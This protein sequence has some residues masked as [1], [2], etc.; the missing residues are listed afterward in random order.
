MTGQGQAEVS[1]PEQSPKVT[2]RQ[3][4]SGSGQAKV[5][6]PGQCPKVQN[7]WQGQGRQNGKNRGN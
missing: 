3:A 1:N 2:E 5:S 6:N 4:G 7:D